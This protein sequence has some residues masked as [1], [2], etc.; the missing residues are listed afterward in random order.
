MYAGANKEIGGGGVPSPLL[1][2]ILNLPLGMPNISAA[3]VVVVG[4]NNTV[5]GSCMLCVRVL[6]KGFVCPKHKR[7]WQKKI[8][9]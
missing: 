3:C 4:L 2:D 7:G 9:F 6:C 5:F 1:E 8:L